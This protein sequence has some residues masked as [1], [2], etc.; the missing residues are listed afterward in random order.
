MTTHRE[1]DS[2]LSVLK[3]AVILEELFR[4]S[5]EKLAEVALCDGEP[6]KDTLCDDTRLA[7]LNGIIYS[8]YTK[9]IDINRIATDLYVS[10]RHL[11]RI[12]KKRFGATIR[13]LINENRLTLAC[14]LL[15]ETDESIGK[16]SASVGFSSKEAFHRAFVKRFCES[17]REY[18][19]KITE[20]K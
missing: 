19:N 7:I 2:V 14:K 9:N 18:R 11:D 16:I 15:L 17:P 13:D 1:V 10:R 20:K 12:A 5:Y 3:L 4:R 8:Q 6:S